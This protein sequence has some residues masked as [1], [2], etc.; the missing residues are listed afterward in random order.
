MS[1]TFFRFLFHEFKNL[2]I[3]FNWENRLSSYYFKFHN[4]LIDRHSQNN[5][6]AL[7]TSDSV[8]PRTVDTS[9]S[10]VVLGASVVV[11]SS[12]IPYSRWGP[13][14]A[15]YCCSGVL[16]PPYCF[17]GTS[18]VPYCCRGALGTSYRFWG[19]SGAPYCCWGVSGAPYCCWDCLWG[20]LKVGPAGFQ[21]EAG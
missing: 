11:D 10:S 21:P 3:I 13:V 4:T 9:S 18:G 14:G 16:G 12:G 1:R 5:I 15:P 19:A 20:R 6:Y 17:W 7:L 2:F 8:M